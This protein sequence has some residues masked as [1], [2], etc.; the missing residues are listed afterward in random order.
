MS[1]KTNVTENNGNA[2]QVGVVN[3]N[4]QE[5]VG[6]YISQFQAPDLYT[7]LNERPIYNLDIEKLN[8]L[9]NKSTL[10][11]NHGYFKTRINIED[12]KGLQANKTFKINKDNFKAE[13]DYKNEGDP[14]ANDGKGNGFQF[15][16]S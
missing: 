12:L 9:P 16:K 13:Y 4:V 5:I 10:L 8:V 15:N 14:N 2:Q 6:Q 11:S 3:I 1:K 7:Y